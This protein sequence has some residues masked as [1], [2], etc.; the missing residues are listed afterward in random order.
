MQFND[1]NVSFK[2]LKQKIYNE[3]TIYYEFE[4]ERFETE[5]NEYLLNWNYNEIDIVRYCNNFVVKIYENKINSVE[6]KISKAT[7]EEDKRCLLRILENYEIGL[8]QFSE[9]N[10]CDM[11]IFQKC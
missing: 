7:D 10:V 8:I 3:H 4:R 6:N 1:K 11:L 5:F 9:H 2:E